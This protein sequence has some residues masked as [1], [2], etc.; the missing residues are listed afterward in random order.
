M[1]TMNG[2][3]CERPLPSAAFEDATVR[4]ADSGGSTFPDTCRSPISEFRSISAPAAGGP[5]AWVRIGFCQ[6]HPA[7]RGYGYRANR[8]KLGRQPPHSHSIVYGSCKHLNEINLLSSAARFTVRNTVEKSR[9]RAIDG[10]RCRNEAEP[11]LQCV[12]RRATSPVAHEQTFL[13]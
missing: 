9:L 11:L 4:L 2:I 7:F 3:D 1:E 10:D 6:I 13:N 8:G 5:Q 12:P